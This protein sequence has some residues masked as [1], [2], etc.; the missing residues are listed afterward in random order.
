MHNS[1][2]YFSFCHSDEPI[3]I[4]YYQQNSR[5]PYFEKGKKQSDDVERLV[6][7]LLLNP[8]K[9]RI[10]QR[11]PIG[12]QENASFVIDTT[13]LNHYEDYKADDLGSFRNNGNKAYV[14]ETKEN[15]VS[16]AAVLPKKFRFP[17]KP[18]QIPVKKTYWI[19]SS[20]KTFKRNST[21]L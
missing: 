14:V 5:T 1:R 15:R 7:I 13:K 10:C 2:L 19:H 8:D 16:S 3:D 17:L 9:D 12:C 20:D 21:E 11:R 4:S 6:E 18:G